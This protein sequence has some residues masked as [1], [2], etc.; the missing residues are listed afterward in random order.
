MIK[1][2]FQDSLNGRPF[3]N[4]AYGHLYRA[5]KKRGND[6]DDA[7]VAAAR[8]A[9]GSSRVATQVPPAY[10]APAPTPA[11]MQVEEAPESY[12][13]AAAPAPAAA[14]EAT[15]KPTPA[16]ILNRIKNRPAR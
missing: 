4:E 10:R 5:F 8:T 12:T 16:D 7:V 6:G 14:P 1:A 15:G 3:D 11:V 9:V 2:M 13:P